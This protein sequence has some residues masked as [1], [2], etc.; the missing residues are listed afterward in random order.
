MS[1]KG[2]LFDKDGTLLD[3]NALWVR[4]VYLS[5]CD[6]LLH[7]MGT[8]EYAAEMM[9]AIGVSNGVASIEGVFCCGTYDDT[10]K[11]LYDCFCR[12]KEGISLE[13]FD[14]YVSEAVKRN[15]SKG[16]IKPV[17][18]NLSLVLSGL[19]SEGMTIGIVTNDARAST[20]KCLNQLGIVNYFDFLSTYDSVLPAKP[21]PARLWDFCDQYGFKPS[22]VIMVGDTLNDMIFANNA[23]ATAVGISADGRNRMILERRADYV[24][25][26]ISELLSLIN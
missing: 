25:E 8:S 5:V 2:I 3:F 12:H 26:N 6:A 16:E 21:N 10:V 13:E 7:F 20:E 15:F 23:G 24:I 4:V 14:K 19:K 18:Y 22:E 1:V 11:V 17:S 9:E